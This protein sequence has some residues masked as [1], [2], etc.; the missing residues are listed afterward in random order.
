MEQDALSIYLR[1]AEHILLTAEDEIILCKKMEGG[2]LSGEEARQ[3]LIKSNL[4]LVIDLAKQ[5]VKQGVPLLD[6]IQEGNIGLMRAANKF[7]YHRGYKFSTFATWW[8]RQMLARAVGNTGRSIRLPIHII[9]A[10]YQLKK[11]RQS[12]LQELKREPMLEELANEMKLSLRKLKKLSEAIAQK[13]ISL[14]LPIG[15]DKESTIEDF[16]KDES[17]KTPVECLA[18]KNLKEDLEDA[19]THLTSRERET[20]ELRFGLVDRVPRTLC[21]VGKKLGVSQSRTDQIESK[22]LCKLR[23]PILKR[24]LRHH[25]ETTP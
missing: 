4:R 23:N 6:L 9:D 11:A 21:E 14:E 20:I 5:F 10:G 17:T 24:K 25:L 18:Q 15:E 3:T 22:S 7:D 2:G 8:V 19:L 12:L 1:E 13:H 16:I